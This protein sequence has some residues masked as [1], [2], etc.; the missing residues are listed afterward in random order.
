MPSS[1]FNCVKQSDLAQLGKAADAHKRMAG[2]VVP[3]ATSAARVLRGRMYRIG[4]GESSIA[5]Y[6]HVVSGFRVWSDSSN[7][8]VG[9]PANTPLEADAYKMDQ[10]YSVNEVAL[11]LAKQSGEI[12]EEFYAQLE[13]RSQSWGQ[14]L[15]QMLGM[16]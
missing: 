7:V 10:I 16:R 9:I 11:S 2:A 13:K 3:A 15:G 1:L 6:R 12:K 5:Q 14:R 4:T 8:Y